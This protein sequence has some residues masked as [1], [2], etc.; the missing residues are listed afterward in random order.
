MM[1]TTAQLSLAERT[2]DYA[3]FYPTGV[4]M[5]DQAEIEQ[6]AAKMILP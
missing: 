1:A 2:E 3:F 6:L 5:P 4:D